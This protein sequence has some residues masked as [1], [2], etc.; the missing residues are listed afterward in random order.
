[1]SRIYLSDLAAVLSDKHGMTRKDAQKFV[2][3]VVTAIQKGLEND[4]LVKIKGLGTFKVIEVEARESIN[5]NT[6]ERYLIESHSKLTF[7]PDAA[8]K[9]LV[10]KPFSAFDT[11]ILNEGV[12]FKDM[13]PE[14]T[15]EIVESLMAEDATESLEITAAA[16]EEETVIDEKPAVEAEPAVEVESVVEVEPVVENEP[17]DGK[18][19]VVEEKIIEDEAPAVEEESVEEGA[20]VVDEP[21]NEDEPSVAEP[22]E[23][24]V[25]KNQ[26]VPFKYWLRWIVAVIAALAIIG[27][28]VWL[29]MSP[30]DDGHP[31]SIQELPAAEAPV[32]Q[33][34]PSASEELSVQEEQPVQD[35]QPSAET[36]PAQEE[37]PAWEKYN[38]MN[39][40]LNFG[41]YYIIGEDYTVK[42][43]QGD[44]SRRI[45][46][47]VFGYEDAS[48]Y[49]EV[50]NGIDPKDVLEAGREVK[51]PK[52]KNKNKV[53][54]DIKQ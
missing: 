15:S 8:M 13:S 47:R 42:A 3:S 7:L 27:L 38:S 33:E 46:N 5:V 22:V 39:K 16:V 43:K 37:Q 10:N 35:V 24:F 28:A 45:A 11:V 34:Q 41:A 49:I 18:K 53:K 6:G 30:G 44:N 14:M 31:A 12:D 4:R 54:T 40:R 1:M 51:I 50:F 21:V 2:T 36:L 9:D 25:E 48:C 20:T 29:F 17:I 52:L 32:V 26:S 19:P 23:A